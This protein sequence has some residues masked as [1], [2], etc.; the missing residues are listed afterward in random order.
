MQARRARLATKAL[1][2]DP[3][4]D[5]ALHQWRD[6]FVKDMARY[7]SAVGLAFTRALLHFGHHLI[8]GYN[9]EKACRA[10]LDYDDL[11]SRTNALLTGKAA[12]AWVLYKIDSGLEHIL[13][14]EAQDTSPAQWRVIGALAEEFFAGEGAMADTALAKGRA[15]ARC[16]PSAMRNS[17]SFPFR[18]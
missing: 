15:R 10:L 13:V 18:G 3:A 9:E 16:L 7:R 5:A 11:I 4:F 14:D 17:P 8:A 12:A 1:L 2:D 6:A